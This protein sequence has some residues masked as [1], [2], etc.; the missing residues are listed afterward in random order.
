M[1]HLEEKRGGE[2]AS[3]VALRQK[4]VEMRMA[5]DRQWEGWRENRI[6]SQ[7][8]GG[9]QGQKQTEKAHVIT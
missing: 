2:R 3:G 6:E 4:R 9:A 1:S 5:L 8:E 7:V